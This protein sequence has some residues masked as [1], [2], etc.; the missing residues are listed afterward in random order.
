[1]AAL[2][3]VLP[4]TE[5]NVS[6]ECLKVNNGNLEDAILVLSIVKDSSTLC[7]VVLP[8]K[9]DNSVYIDI[10]INIAPINLTGYYNDIYG[11]QKRAE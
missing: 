6:C 4:N 11:T 1:M 7:G 9:H 10:I 2:R 8:G 3:D 5:F